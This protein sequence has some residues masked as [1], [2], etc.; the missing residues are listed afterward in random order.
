M[1]LQKWIVTVLIPFSSDLADVAWGKSLLSSAK[2]KAAT[3]IVVTGSSSGRLFSVGLLCVP[4]Q[5]PQVKVLDMETESQRVL[6][7][8]VFSLMTQ[9]VPRTA[10]HHPQLR[11]PA[12][13]Q[14]DSKEASPN[15]GSQGCRKHL[16]QTQTKKDPVIQSIWIYTEDGCSSKQKM[17]FIFFKC[18]TSF[19]FFFLILFHL[20]K[21]LRNLIFLLFILYLNTQLHIINRRD[22]LHTQMATP[23][24]ASYLDTNVN[25]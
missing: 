22:Y 7:S 17:F 19:L 12:T 18:K 13:R 14:T 3:G 6:L 10:K 23:K 24:L 5:S 21:W 20:P 2:L 25:P 9:L 1:E 4:M 16:W 8:K 11:P 15:S